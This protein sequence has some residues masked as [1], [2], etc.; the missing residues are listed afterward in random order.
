MS[1]R[2]KIYIAGPY[3]LGD[4]AVNVHNAIRLADYIASL[5]AVPYVPH[6]N[7]FWHLMYAREYRFW[8]K[9]DREWLECCDAMVRIEGESK[10]ADE[11]EQHMRELGKPVH[12]FRGFE[13]KELK[14][15][16]EFLTTLQCSRNSS[17]L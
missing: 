13:L 11:E 17:S 14:R 16:D 1:R 3:T 2:V 12:N 8:M 6:L 15:L 9:Y 10:G 4:T 5:G 7:H